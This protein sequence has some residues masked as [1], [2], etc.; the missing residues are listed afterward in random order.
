MDRNGK[1]KNPSIDWTPNAIKFSL[2]LSFPVAI[3][4]ELQ[5]EPWFGSSYVEDDVSPALLKIWRDP[6]EIDMLLHLP[7]R[8][9]FIPCDF[10]LHANNVENSPAYTSSPRCVLDEALIKLWYKL[11]NTFKVP[12][13]NTYFRINLNGAYDDARTCL[14]TEFFILLLK[15]E[16][17][18]IIYQ[19][20]Y[21]V[22]PV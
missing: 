21:S 20:S 18:E 14:M 12:R 2:K 19:V 16:L 1:K 13:A 4:S 7:M 8:N 9:D 15:D 6:P 22:V 5:L 17:N 11:D 3:A 10:S